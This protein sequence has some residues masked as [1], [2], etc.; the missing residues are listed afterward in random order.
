MRT[1]PVALVERG[2]CCFVL[3]AL[4]V[5][6]E[7]NPSG[8]NPEVP[9][10]SQNR[11]I[12]EM[13]SEPEEDG[14]ALELPRSVDDHPT[15]NREGDSMDELREAE[16]L[17]KIGDFRGALTIYEDLYVRLPQREGS[18]D[19]VFGFFYNEIGNC[20]RGLGEYA[21]ALKNYLLAL[22]VFRQEGGVPLERVVLDNVREICRVCDRDDREYGVQ[23]YT[24]LADCFRRRN[25]KRSLILA[26]RYLSL[27]TDISSWEGLEW[28]RPFVEESEIVESELGV[29]YGD[30]LLDDVE[31]E[32]FYFLAAQ[33]HEADGN[34]AGARDA[35]IQLGL[36]YWEAGRTVDAVS[37]F[38]QVR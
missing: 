20:Y 24:A 36:K 1:L 4:S 29:Y 6:C 16:R 35:R 33:C 19:P 27:F 5:A 21:E 26:L 13:S 25:E 22:L 3:A 28:G 18:V 7:A 14:S 31:R 9:E 17:Y 30:L 34:I 8:N 10:V 37:V 11:Q 23:Y 15:E 38:A 32:K 12:V 2:L